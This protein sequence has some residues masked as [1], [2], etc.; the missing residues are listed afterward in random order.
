[1]HHI[2]IIPS[3]ISIGILLFLNSCAGPFEGYLMQL[4][5]DNNNQATP[6]QF[7]VC[8]GNGCVLRSTVSL[9]GQPWNEVM[10]NFKDASNSPE[11]ERAQIS[12]AISLIEVF[13]GKKIGS[14]TDVGQNVYKY[15]DE[16]QMDCVDETINTSMYL[17][18]LKESGALRWHRVEIPLHRGFFWPHNTAVV[19]EIKSGDRYVIDSW[20]FKNGVEPS[21]VTAEEWLAGWRP[22]GID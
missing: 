14:H 11:D 12:K 21:I 9:A 5:M 10:E 22:P 18:F 8:H 6:G 3:I 4:E 15:Y 2:R 7:T 13:V 19:S 17:H 20:F 16:G 1:M